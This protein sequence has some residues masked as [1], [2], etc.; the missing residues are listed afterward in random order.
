MALT[1]DALKLL[2]PYMR[3]ARVLCFGY[4]DILAT[5]VEVHDVLGVLV[6]KTTEFGS[7]HK[8]RAGLAETRE[9]FAALGASMRCIDVNPSRGEEEKLDLNEE[10]PTREYIGEFDLV[11]DAG[12]IEHCAN[13]GQAI[14]NAMLAVRPGGHVFHSPPLSMVNHG[15]YN[16]CPTLL[17][18][19]Y[20]QNGWTVK[21]LS[22]F[23]KS[24]FE[25]L[26]IEPTTRYKVPNDMAMY[27]LAQC[28]PDG[29]TFHWPKQSRY[30]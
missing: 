13:I 5:P 19:M 21:H 9:V 7:G 28:P 4:P 3:N 30:T 12:T 26:A 29:G 18:D 23:H 20:T 6:E 11:I 24:T 27:F 16:V 10:W 8:I 17:Y 14:R 15:F 1:K 2:A 22:A 25:P